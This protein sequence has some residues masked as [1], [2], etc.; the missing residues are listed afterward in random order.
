MI[1]PAFILRLSVYFN[2]IFF[3]LHHADV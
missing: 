2:P 1:A 3:A